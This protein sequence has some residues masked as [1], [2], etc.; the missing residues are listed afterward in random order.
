MR[1]DDDPG[2]PSRVLHDGDRVDL[3][4]S[5]VHHACAAHV[6]EPGGPAVALANAG[7]A[8][9]HVKSAKRSYS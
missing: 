6:S 8:T 1:R 5:L 9:A 7:L 3:L 4:Q 2:E